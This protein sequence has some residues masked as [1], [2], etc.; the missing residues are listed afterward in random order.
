MANRSRLLVCAVVGS[1]AWPCAAAAEVQWALGKEKGR[2]FLYGM[3]NESEVD[4]EFWARCRADKDIGSAR[5]ENYARTKVVVEI[6]VVFHPIGERAGFER[7][8]AIDDD[9]GRLTGNVGIDREDAL[10]AQGRFG[11]FG[12]FSIP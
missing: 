2:A 6:A 1:L 4:Y 8:A 9:A 12:Q 11:T 3:H 7:G 5:L 10:H